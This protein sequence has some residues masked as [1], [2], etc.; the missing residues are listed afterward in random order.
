MHTYCSV[1]HEERQLKKTKHLKTK[2][3]KQKPINSN[4]AMKI[5]ALLGATRGNLLNNFPLK[6]QKHWQSKLQ[7]RSE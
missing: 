3:H 6:P 1:K 7:N 5:T 4:A 2:C